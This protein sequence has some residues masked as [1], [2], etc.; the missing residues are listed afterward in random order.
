VGVTRVA[1]CVPSND[2]VWAWFAYDLARMVGW[3]AAQ[4]PDIELRLFNA[5]G[6]WLVELREKLVD[7]ALRADCTHILFLDS[8]MRFEKD[9]LVRLLAHDEPV[10][11][12]NYT[13]RR[14][15]FHPVSVKSLGDPMTRVY[16][17]EESEG[18]EPVAATGMGVMLVQADLVRSV[19]PPRFMMGWVPDDAAHV[20]EDLYFC[21]K[22][23]DAGATILVDHDLSKQVTHIGMVEFEAQHAVASRA[24][25]QTR[26]AV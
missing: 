19:K 16:T 22:L 9:A 21:K 17:E 8:D 5:T 14:P 11:A 1:I 15:P 18:L 20:G 12:A 3:T 6:C 24:S 2:H 25:V 10:V 7:A 4:H 23:T 26:A 13:T